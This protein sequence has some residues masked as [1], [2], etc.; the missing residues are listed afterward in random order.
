MPAQAAGIGVKAS[1]VRQDRALRH[2]TAFKRLQHTTLGSLTNPR[3]AIPVYRGLGRAIDRAARAVSRSAATTATQRR[4]RH[5]WVKGARLEARGLAQIATALRDV[6]HDKRL[7]ARR[8]ARQAV[9]T[10]K[11]GGRLAAKGDRL[12]GLP[13]TD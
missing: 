1:I 3:K 4:A 10:V 2:S 13:R 11:R 5:D 6:E 8:E 12:L 9:V 7:A